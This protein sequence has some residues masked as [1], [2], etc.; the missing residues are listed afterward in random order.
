MITIHYNIGMRRIALNDLKNWLYS[1]T[2]KPLILRGARQV[3]KSTLIELFSKQER[4]DLI[5]FDLEIEDLPYLSNKDC[6]IQ[7]LIDEIQEMRIFLL[8]KY[9][10]NRS[11][12]QNP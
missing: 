5:R 6:N 3:G 7:N 9:F 4:L 8:L 2:R 12:Y 1:S 10:V 11:C